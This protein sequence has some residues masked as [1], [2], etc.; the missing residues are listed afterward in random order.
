MTA[1][2]CR[3]HGY[4]KDYAQ[5]I[6]GDYWKDRRWIRCNDLCMDQGSARSNDQFRDEESEFRKK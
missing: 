5:L 1:C 4:F 6:D 3:S 2:L